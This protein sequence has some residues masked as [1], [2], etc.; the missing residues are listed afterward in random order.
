MAHG[1]EDLTSCDVQRERCGYYVSAMKYEGWVLLPER[2]DDLGVSGATLERPALERLRSLCVQGRLDVVVVT[3]LDRLTR[4]MADWARLSDWFKRAG[5]DLVIVDGNAGASGPLA[6]LVNNVVASFAEFEREL[7]SERQRDARGRARARGLRTAGRVPLGYASDPNTKQ[8]V[9]NE[10]EAPIVREFFE[11]SAAGE[12]GAQIAAW[13]NAEGHRT[14]VHAG[15]GGVLWTGRAVLQ[16]LRNPLYLGRRSHQAAT[17]KGVHDAIVDAKLAERALDAIDARRTR[18]PSSRGRAPNLDNDPWMLR[19]ILRCGGCGRLMT[20]S[21]SARVTLA[22]AD[23]VPRYY[24]CRGEVGRPACRPAVQVAA[25]RVEGQVISRLCLPQ[26]VWT[27]N[28]R[29]RAF[30]RL[31][32][33]EWP[34]LDTA[35]RN[36]LVRRLLWTITLHPHRRFASLTVDELGADALIEENPGLAA[37]FP[38]RGV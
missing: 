9:I 31:L 14:K 16:I 1:N 36:R 37:G 30:L 10:R 33:P 27:D 8:L 32:A 23:D 12:S 21:A 29:A 26:S 34:R 28:P 18:S 11:R 19:G 7:V 4:R 20:T 17:V 35:T 2:F 6:S 22:N 13:A 25:H 15:K 5:V 3:R 24:R 38:P